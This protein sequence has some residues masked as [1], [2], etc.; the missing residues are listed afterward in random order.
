MAH[1]LAVMSTYSQREADDL[2]FTGFLAAALAEPPRDSIAELLNPRHHSIHY[3]AVDDSAPSNHAPPAVVFIGDAIIAL[4][5]NETRDWLVPSNQRDFLASPQRQ[6]WQASRDRAIVEWRG[7][8]VFEE[9]DT[10]PDGVK[11]I[12]SLWVDKLKHHPDGT[13]ACKS[14]PC[15][16]DKRPQDDVFSPTPQMISILAII[17]MGTA[18]SATMEVIDFQFDAHCAFQQTRV[19]H[20]DEA[21]YT[22][23]KPLPGYGRPGVH[24]RLLAHAQGTRPAAK[25][26]RL[27][28]TRRIAAIG[29]YPAFADQCVFLHT[30]R[31]AVFG[32]HVDDGLGW[33]SCRATADTLAAFLEKE[34]PGSA[35][36]GWNDYV[37]YEVRRDLERQTTT[38]TAQRLIEKLCNDLLDASYTHAPA[39]PSAPSIM[40]L[41][42]EAPPHPTDPSYA[43]YA[44]RQ[45]TVRSVLGSLIFITS[46]RVEARHATT[47]CCR[48]MSNPSA[49]VLA[50]VQ[51]IMLYL[52]ATKLD[53]LTYHADA[54][55]E[56]RSPDVGTFN[57]TTRRPHYT[58]SSPTPTS[59]QT[60]VSAAPSTCWAEP[61]SR[62]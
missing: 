31:K 30:S 61:P 24:W 2:I 50:A 49:A 18:A 43:Q 15:I 34:Y 33:T 52:R 29:F 14:R 53:G 26:F 12:N 45:S 19:T 44:M 58:T 32:L 38:V 16:I 27:D 51:H 6:Q 54:P 62:R 10:L 37:G 28:F 47:R 20:T 1:S 8:D 56:Q 48:H 22:Y 35:F 17:A 25:E 3:L 9:V 41:T 36:A 11:A 23:I 21:K 5:A 4:T 42:G 55:L 46:V 13:V 59:R 7:L 40:L 57:L 60:A 39:T